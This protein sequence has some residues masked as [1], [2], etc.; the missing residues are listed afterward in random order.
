MH[1]A[2]GP[3]AFSIWSTLNVCALLLRLLSFLLHVWF[4][5]FL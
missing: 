5:R 4:P 2:L 3:T 1:R